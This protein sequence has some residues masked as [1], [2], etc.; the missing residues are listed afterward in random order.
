MEGVPFGVILELLCRSKIL[1]KKITQ[2][3]ETLPRGAPCLTRD[4]EGARTHT[5]GDSWDFSVI[6]HH[7]FIMHHEVIC[8]PRTYDPG[9]S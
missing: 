4:T 6:P 3:K 2:G 5:H 7:V 9:H 1:S 8:A